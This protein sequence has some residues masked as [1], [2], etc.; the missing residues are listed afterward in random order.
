MATPLDIIRQ[1]GDAVVLIFTLL[2]LGVVVVQVWS[3]IFYSQRLADLREKWRS[4]QEESDP[5]KKKALL[6]QFADEETPLGSRIQ[7]ANQ[8]ALRKRSMGIQE[9]SL[10]TEE[11]DSRHWHVIIP[12]IAISTFLI[13]GL[14]GTVYLL[15]TLMAA[16]LSQGD[17]VNEEGKLLTDK[18]A[19]VINTLY[20]GFSHIFWA[21]FAGIIATLLILIIRNSFVYRQ[22]MA[23]FLA[24]DKFTIEF[25]L[26]LDEKLPEILAPFI[27][28]M[29]DLANTIMETS[30]KN[31]ES[32]DRA[33]KANAEAVRAVG[34]V[35]LENARVAF[36][37]VNDLAQFTSAMN[38]AAEKMNQ[39]SKE[40]ATSN[41]VLSATFASDG[42]WAKLHAGLIA[43][44]TKL[45]ESVDASQGKLEAVLT[46]LAGLR[47]AAS[48]LAKVDYQG[49]QTGLGEL[50][51]SLTLSESTWSQLK[52]THDNLLAELV[53]KPSSLNNTL[54][55]LNASVADLGPQL[56]NTQTTLNTTLEG[57]HT[58]VSSIDQHLPTL[59]SDL[60]KT[61]THVLQLCASI[62]DLNK[63]NFQGLHDGINSL[64]SS[65]RTAGEAFGRLVKTQ[66]EIG[67]DMLHAQETVELASASL[68]T[69]LA[70][71]KRQIS[72]IH[73]EMTDASILLRS[74]NTNAATLGKVDFS[75]L[76]QSLE[77][78]ADALLASPLNK[79][80]PALHKEISEAIVLMR[81]WANLAESEKTAAKLERIL[82]ALL[83]LEAKISA[84]QPIRPVK[85]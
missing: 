40:L 67:K 44:Q 66:Q 60:H 68:D 36:K 20:P 3:G 10:L 27:K 35:N 18:M 50:S 15:Q 19:A 32:I 24:V 79:T 71:L 52:V 39:A 28:S 59:Q 84:S 83:G 85:K 69:N 41:S 54:L 82:S 55:A 43:S 75:G 73:S 61:S 56:V 81:D 22:R 48:S 58:S 29:A 9:L 23:F 64:D 37:A 57:F 7:L 12:N 65:L 2:T 4:L 16:V 53:A 38:D 33:S 26:P 30:K 1:Q 6:N 42:R 49:L 21:T 78:T 46:N 11:E 63:A 70:E 76:S 5:L 62:T 31:T 77:A 25:L 34:L 72:S 47:A 14:A 45:K 17:I 51:N 80:I 8:A 13:A 74:V